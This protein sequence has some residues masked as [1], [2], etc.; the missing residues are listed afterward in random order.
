MKIPCNHFW[1]WLTVIVLGLWAW[2]ALHPT[3]REPVRNPGH[4]YE[5]LFDRNFD[6]CGPIRRD[7]KGT[8]VDI[9]PVPPECKKVKP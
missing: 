9:D 5:F 1:F 8:S 6:P 2:R 3:V 4:G 7:L